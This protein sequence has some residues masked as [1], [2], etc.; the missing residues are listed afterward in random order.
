MA[1]LESAGF[2]AMREDTRPKSVRVDV[3]AQ[4]PP[5]YRR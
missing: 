3:D 4:I 2:E 1:M 5:F